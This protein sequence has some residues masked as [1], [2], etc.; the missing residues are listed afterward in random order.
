[1]PFFLSHKPSTISAQSSKKPSRRKA[2]NAAL[3]CVACTPHSSFGL[4]DSQAMDVAMVLAEEYVRAA[5]PYTQ[6]ASSLPIET[7]SPPLSPQTVSSH[8]TDADPT[9]LGLQAVGEQQQCFLEAGLDTAPQSAFT[10]LP[11]AATRTTTVA[12][13]LPSP[14]S[15]LRISSGRQHR[16]VFAAED[17]MFLSLPLRSTRTHT[18]PR[19]DMPD[20]RSR[21]V[22][23][24]STVCA[25]AVLWG[26]IDEDAGTD[27][28]RRRSQFAHESK[29]KTK[30]PLKGSMRWVRRLF[31]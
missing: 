18:R 4:T 30:N 27:V 14:T 11:A 6:P 10:L 26:K 31:E 21:T 8:S 13:A 25:P 1:M 9:R 20:A 23:S 19:M 16:P 2:A 17:Q 28:C 15:T 3:S 22:S 5:E 7:P 12:A 29:D 24:N